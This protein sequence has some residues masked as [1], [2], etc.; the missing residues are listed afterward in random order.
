M[1]SYGFGNPG[2][3]LEQAHKYGGV[4]LFNGIPT[5]IFSEDTFIFK[6]LQRLTKINIVF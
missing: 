6:S 1:T 3:V 2:P 5:S 4:K